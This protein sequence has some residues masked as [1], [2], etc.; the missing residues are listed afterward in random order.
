MIYSVIYSIFQ[1]HYKLLYELKIL[2][3][4]FTFNHLIHS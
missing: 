4:H 1:F 2:F 3:F